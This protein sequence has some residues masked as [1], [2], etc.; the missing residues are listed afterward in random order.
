MFQCHRVNGSN[1]LFFSFQNHAS[2]VKFYIGQWHYKSGIEMPAWERRLFPT[3]LTRRIF[4]AEGNYAMTVLKL[5]SAL[6]NLSEFNNYARSLRAIGQDL[7]KLY[8]EDLEIQV[9]ASE[10][11]ASGVGLTQPP[12]ERVEPGNVIKRGWNRLTGKES[13]PSLPVVSRRGERFTRKYTLDDINRLDEIGLPARANQGGKPDI[14]SLGE[15]LRTV[16]RI[17]DAC[18]GT[19]LRVVKDRNSIKFEYQDQNGHDLRE[20]YTNLAL[21]KY[22]QQYYAERGTF[23]FIDPWDKKT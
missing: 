8:P 3:P 7:T 18:K 5:N 1:Y 6:K 17:V 23:T 13:K 15:R 12:Q 2:T 4:V 14:Y 11:L 9:N 20:E 19:L 10:F 21:Y 22:Q 16:G